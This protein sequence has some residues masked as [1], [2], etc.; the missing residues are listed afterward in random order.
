MFSDCI[1]RILG[2][3]YKFLLPVQL[4]W[5]CSGYDKGNILITRVNSCRD[6]Y[7]YMWLMQIRKQN[8]DSNEVTELALGTNLTYAS[9]P[10]S[11]SPKKQ[12]RSLKSQTQMIMVHFE[13]TKLQNLLGHITSKL[14]KINTLVSEVIFCVAKIS[15]R[16]PGLL[17]DD[18]DK[19]SDCYRTA[20]M[21]EKMV[22]VSEQ[23]YI[24]Y[25]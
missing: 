20:L 2:C 13:C 7:K 1:Y 24:H 18:T 17:A 3:Y 14:T 23:F 10:Q 15:V 6:L 16:E 11:G 8:S 12:L 21:M 19:A 22:W 9:L 4:G 25:T 5:F